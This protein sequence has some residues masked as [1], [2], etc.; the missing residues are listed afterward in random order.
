MSHRTRRLLY[1]VSAAGLL[2]TGWLL[3]GWL[4]WWPPRQ[5]EGPFGAVLS[6]PYP[7]D[8]VAKSAGTTVIPATFR[9]SAS[10]ADL[11]ATKAFAWNLGRGSP[12]KMASETGPKV[13]LTEAEL[14]RQL[15]EAPELIGEDIRP[16]GLKETIAKIAALAK[17]I[18]EKNKKDLDGYI[19]K[20]IETRPD[21]TG[22]PFVLGKDCQLSKERAGELDRASR[23]A[24]AILEGLRKGDGERFWA[25]WS[26]RMGIAPQEADLDALVQLLP[27]EADFRYGIFKWL[28][29]RALPYARPAKSTSLTLARQALFAFE[30]ELRTAATMA[31][32]HRP[33]QDYAATL[34]EGL[35]HPW[36]P[37]AVHAAQALVMLG[38]VDLLPELVALLD[39]PDPTAPFETL[40]GNSR[41]FQVREMVRINHHRN[42]LLCHPPA[43]SKTDPVA[44]A[45]SIPGESFS[46][47]GIARLLDS[48]SKARKDLEPVFVRADVTYLRQ[49][50]SAFLP[51]RDY[52]AFCWPEMQRFDFLVR[53][54]TLTE[55]EASRAKQDAKEA[56][57]SPH[58][59][60]LLY[61]LRILADRLDLDDSP[62]AWRAILPCYAR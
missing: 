17:K 42:C 34:L 39:L 52:K 45:I 19:R 61:A 3:A 25:E 53:T 44:G 54:R 6:G 23:A 27:P 12:S 36:G 1:V 57:P 15:Q 2:V 18:N 5:E 56:R 29:R 41:V 11:G 62:A 14:W 22:L 7:G 47:A 8:S 58:R 32:V 51:M 31:L 24:R 60:A 10:R 48:D 38:R 49:D 20:L 30:P 16:G 26:L 35:R 55:A 9:G 33:A 43:T 50:F 13:T 4:G 21:L 28:E 46:Y 59:Q 40:A 37:V